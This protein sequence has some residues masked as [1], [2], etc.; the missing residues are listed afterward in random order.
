MT[1]GSC[2]E[3]VQ[4]ALEGIEGVFASAVDY[5]NGV[6]RIAF[7]AKKIDRKALVAAIVSTGFKAAES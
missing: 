4:A 3:K 7:D 2:A 1:C 6:A 5:Q